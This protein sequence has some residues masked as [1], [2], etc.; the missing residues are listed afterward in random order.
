L[1]QRAEISV[2][3]TLKGGFS[4]E[5]S[6]AILDI[7]KFKNRRCELQRIPLDIQKKQ[8]CLKNTE[9]KSSKKIKERLFLE[10]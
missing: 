3:I 10:K 2:H 8:F 1:S 6:A 9:K 5:K 7:P 4:A